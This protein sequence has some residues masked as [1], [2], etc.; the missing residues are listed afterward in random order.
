MQRMH[1]SAQQ[2]N[3]QQQR[4]HHTMHQQ[5]PFVLV[6]AMNAQSNGVMGSPQQAQHFAPAAPAGGLFYVYVPP[7]QN[8]NTLT[9]HPQQ[10]TASYSQHSADPSG[11][12][13]GQMYTSQATPHM[14][15]PLMGGHQDIFSHSAPVALMG[16]Q[17]NAHDLMG[18]LTSIPQHLV[19]PTFLAQSWGHPGGV[20]PAMAPPPPPPPRGGGSLPPPGSQQPMIHRTGNVHD[21]LRTHGCLYV[22]YDG[23]VLDADEVATGAKLQPSSLAGVALTSTPST[24]PSSS[25][26]V[27]PNDAATAVNEVLGENASEETSRQPPPAGGSVHT[28]FISSFPTEKMECAQQLLTRVLQ[29]VCSGVTDVPEGRGGAVLNHSNEGMKKLPT[30][31]AI[32]FLN[33]NSRGSSHSFYAKIHTDE[34]HELMKHLKGAV[35]MDRLGF[36]WAVTVEGRRYLEQYSKSIWNLPQALRHRRTE[37]LP[38][39][40]LIVDVALDTS[41][42]R[43][44]SQ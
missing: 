6:N 37:W 41:K 24:S 39:T 30:V 18:S 31:S 36:H 5:Q 38:C 27:L 17:S 34:P 9:S 15:S 32:S 7:Q 21:A 14:I 26:G 23:P 16:S 19:Q 29:T 28:F 4:H 35:M 8:S 42:V 40:P 33:A 3:G 10:L 25:L 2:S 11:G 13:Y 44:Y 12:S 43:W 20:H 22:P 1:F